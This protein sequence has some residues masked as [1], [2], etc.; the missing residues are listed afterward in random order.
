MEIKINMN[1]VTFKDNSCLVR[2]STSAGETRVNV[3]TTEK[4]NKEDDSIDD[5]I[6]KM[7]KKSN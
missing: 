1:N 2:T 7:S 6:I 3:R 4:D 5:I